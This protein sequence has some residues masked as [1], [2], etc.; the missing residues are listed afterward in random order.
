MRFDKFRH[1][2]T[3]AAGIA[4]PASTAGDGAGTHTVVELDENQLREL[5]AVF[6]APRWLRDLGIAAWLLVGVAALLVGLMFVLGL[7]STIVE[8]VLVGLVLATVAAPAVTWLQ[9]HRFPRAAGAGVVLLTL[10]GLGVVIVLL[11]I[12]GITA[13]SDKI[14]AQAAKGAD[15]VAAWVKDVGVDDSAADSANSS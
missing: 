5:S 11:V 7:T 4:T 10:V 8:P 6:S 2:K 14:A 13:E 3:P 1:H 12:G 9:R 15:K